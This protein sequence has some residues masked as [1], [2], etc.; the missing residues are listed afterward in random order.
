MLEFKLKSF[1]VKIDPKQ[2][3]YIV[4]VITFL[5]YKM[6]LLNYV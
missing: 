5:E 3:F 6:K 1:M 2:D 4:H